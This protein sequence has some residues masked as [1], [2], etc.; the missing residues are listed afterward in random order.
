MAPNHVAEEADGDHASGEHAHSAEQ[1]LAR[2]RRQDVRNDPNRRQ[3]G[4]IDLRV[5]EEPE[6]VLPEER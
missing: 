5:A 6:Q 3:D 2:E 4:D 1:R